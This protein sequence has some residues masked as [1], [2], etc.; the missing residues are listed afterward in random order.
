MND[1]AG[2][3]VERSG[4]LV[5]QNQTIS[6]VEVDQAGGRIYGQRRTADNQ[7]I[8]PAQGV[9]GAPQTFWIEFFTIEHDIRPDAAATGAVRHAGTGENRF[10][11]ERTAAFQAVIALHAAMQLDHIAAA[12][13]LVQ[14]IDILGDDGGQAPGGL[15][16]RQLAVGGVRAGVGKDQLFAIETEEHLG[17]LLEERMAQNGFRRIGIVLTVNA[18][19]AAEIG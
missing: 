7:H 16:L 13:Q 11:R 19:R 10:E 17:L 12:G 18:G 9:K 3:L 15:E 6:L 1:K 8:G 2:L 14:P 4:L 5:D